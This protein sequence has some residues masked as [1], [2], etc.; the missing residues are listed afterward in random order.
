MDKLLLRD[1]EPYAS[2]HRHKRRWY[3]VM[4][5]LAA[6]VVFCTTY[7]LILPAITLEKQCAL[8]EHTHT[9][10]CY[11]SEQ[12]DLIC[13][14]STEPQHTHTEECYQE[15]QDLVCGMSESTGH[16]HGA[17]CYDGEGNLICGQEESEGHIH[18]EACYGVSRQ[19]ICG[20]T[21]EPAHQHTDACYSWNQVLTCD[22]EEHTHSEAC[23]ATEPE[24]PVFCGKEP[25]THGESCRD[26]QG[27]LTCGME[28]HTHSEACTATEPEEPVFCGK[29]PHTHGEDCRDEQGELT[30]TLEE[31]THSLACYADPTADVE[32]AEIWEQTFGDVTLT[33]DWRLDALAIARSQLGYA[34]STKNY[35][36]AEDGQTLKGYTRYG[37]W[38][39]DPYGDWNA[40]FAAFCLHYGGAENIPTDKD[41]GS[42]A[43]ALADAFL[44]A[45][46]HEAAPGELVFFDRDG[47]GTADW[48]AIV[49]EV[50]AGEEGAPSG[51]TVIAGDADNAVQQRSYALEDPT[52]LGYYGSLPE[53][54]KAFTLTA[55]TESGITVTVTGDSASLPF[56]VSEITLTAAEVAEEQGKAIREQLPAEEGTEPE[57]RFLLDIALWHGEEEIEP[58]GPVTV[59]FSGLD[60]QG[61]YPKVYHI[62]TDTQ[63]VRD[64]EA[65]KTE[66]GD[67]AVATDHFSLY[68][69]SLAA[70]RDLTDTILADTF[71]A[72]G[73]Y[74]LTADVQTDPNIDQ[75]L[76]TAA[77]PTT[78]DLNGHTLTISKAGQH[79]FVDH[80]ATLTIVDSSDRIQ[81]TESTVTGDV[82]GNK[83][84]LENDT[85]TYYITKSTPTGTGTTET[86][87]KHEVPLTGVGK[88]LCQE[89]SE[90]VIL[91]KGAL[92]LQ[93][94]VLQNTGGQ[95][96]VT[97]DSGTLNMTG[98][99]IVG[100]GR[101]GMPGGG[102]Y[103]DNG[104]VNIQGGV[105]AANRGSSGGGIYFQNGTLNIS[106]GAVTGNEVINGHTDNGGGIYVNSGTLNLSGGYVTN[107]YKAC[108]CN[109]CQNDV[110]N[111]HGGGGIALANNATM[112]MTG[113]YVTGNYSGL[114]GGGIYAGFWGGGV[115][116][117][118]SGGTIAGNCA[119]LGEGGGL[120]I[121]GGTNGVIRATGKVYI[122]NNKT[123]SDDDWG[124]GGIFVQESGN[125]TIM[126]ALITNNH[127][128]G[129]GGGVGAC[130]TGK[131]L[132]VN[133]DG[134]AIYGN[135]AKGERMSDGGNG[136]EYDTTV[137][138]ASTVF[139][140][141][142]YTDYFCVRKK[143]GANDP[144]SLVTGLMAGGGAAN[145]KGSCDEKVVSISKSGYA[146]AKYLFGLVAN[147]DDAAK[148]QAV[149][150]AKV[151]ITGNYSGVH[152]GGIMTNGGLILGNPG[153][154][155]VVT[156]TPELDIIGTKA[157]LKDGVAQES[158]LDFTFQL[159]DNTGKV[160][161]TAT[162]DAATGQFTISPDEQYSEAETRT[163][164]LS[165]VK[166]NRAGITY[167]TNVHTIQVT[168]SERIVSLLGV[169]FKS[170][171]VSSVTLDGSESGGSSGSGSGTGSQTGTFRV[172]YQNTNNWAN[173]NVYVWDAAKNKIVGE[174]PGKP[175]TKDTDGTYYYDLTVTGTGTY[176]YIFNNG[177]AQTNDIVNVPYAPGKEAVFNADGGIVSN[178]A[179]GDSSGSGDAVGR[180]SNLDG[181]YTL[182]IP[183]AAFTNT[184]TTRLDLQI[185]KTDSVDASKLL[186]GAEFTLK[187]PGT[188]P[189]VKVTTGKDGIAAFTGIRRNTTYDLYETQAPSNYMTAGPWILE[190]GSED[191]TLYPATENPDGT[192]T[193]TGETG[194][195][196]TVSG[197]DPK[198]L[199]VTVR[200]ISWG[201]KLPD[202][203]GAGTTSYTAGGLALIFGAA[204]LMYIHCKR[205]K[206]DEASS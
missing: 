90:Q 145:W 112:D 190:V 104:T 39:G 15:T 179:A 21:E 92:E 38:K 114:A 34:E 185:V 180:G 70:A 32:T 200:D 6:A 135:A 33:G 26:E 182:T 22:L 146:A 166:G 62:D 141:N 94:G 142:G 10:A 165:E 98:G 164:T 126:D 12:G 148:S 65:E 198:V 153:E 50:T 127:A 7:A 74:K 18:G 53:Q 201:Y 173:V 2:A 96:I 60:T 88:I 37:A 57:Q 151:I 159:T 107:N 86:L 43:A 76:I 140:E 95:H 83:A 75:V 102:I 40:L 178:T 20:Q 13:T 161:G 157:L 134:A 93:S 99:Y 81:D 195:L 30:C 196:L 78:I 172:R 4:T 202:T 16:T 42:W 186:E 59:T 174:W 9:E 193:Q 19:L 139:M 68:A 45:Q 205:R 144:I 163:Y 82:C 48:V 85:L 120:R 130:P 55:Q 36:L 123:N 5:C 66:N 63:T 72:G 203:G 97:V 155:K 28:E 168:V 119:A 14:Q 41:C 35:V 111:K 125:L 1:A 116:F 46:S 49:A 152:G 31:H 113:G 17:E 73:E 52:I 177:S 184:M 121:A 150:A 131:T 29:E 100:G 84:S 181:S 67:V 69:I 156:A 115:K 87:V 44:P 167:D 162:S 24:K 154:T 77:N 101:D 64:M 160:L 118:M 23:T 3:Q 108:D 51:I 91:V 103:V 71:Q 199:S 122:T 110:N 8:P 197:T 143:E 137:A 147:P 132:I 58:V 105:I 176:N 89:A 54:A 204:T 124:G 170:Y 169:T 129:F 158:G 175:M 106:G 80:G 171:Y 117:T 56:P 11:T 25:H 109:D 183:G 188:E 133:Q 136:K 138:K 191:A 149:N 189:P 206:E 128:E 79:F 192:L 194:T 61:L 187:E 27:E 47:D